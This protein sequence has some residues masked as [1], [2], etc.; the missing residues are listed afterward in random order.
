MHEEK[1]LK[2]QTSAETLWQCDA[3]ERCATHTESSASLISCPIVR[4]DF[5][6]RSLVAGASIA[7]LT[8]S[9]NRLSALANPQ[10][11]PNSHVATQLHT[12]GVA[13]NGVIWHTIRYSN[14]AHWQSSFG[15][16]NAQESNGNT[17]QFQRVACAGGNNLL[18]VVAL[19][20]N[21]VIWHTIRYSNSAQWQSFFGNVNAQESNGGSLGFTDV[22]CAVVGQDLHICGVDTNGVIWHTIRYSSPAH[23]QS[24]FGNV[25]AQESN[26]STL[27]FV[28]VGCASV[29]GNLHIC[30][31]DTN[32]VIWHTIRY[33]NPAHWQSFF[34]NVNAQESNG[35]SL[36]F[37]DVDCAN[38]GQDL[39]VC[40]AATNGVI[41]HTIRYS[42]PAHW[43]SFF[44]NVNAQESNGNIIQFT[45]ISTGGI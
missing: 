41:W 11:I 28:R 9:G 3:E 27:H 36:S 15:N 2:N 31:V 42:N 4:R 8:L 37:T 38:V 13:T 25:N 34:G 39:H 1:T 14:P 6:V 45:A 40:G 5:L 24:F 30:G 20:Q 29:N 10:V 44:G 22:D 26:G 17:L 12:C 33:S 21:G 18:H 23:W 35:G 16:V 7:G 19:A 43:Q 32:G